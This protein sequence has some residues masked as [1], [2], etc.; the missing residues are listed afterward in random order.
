MLARASA[1]LRRSVSA[2]S[3]PVVTQT[4]A[5]GMGTS[6]APLFDKILIANRGEIVGRVA[7]T[8]NRMGEDVDSVS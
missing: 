4:A 3:W 5:R 1:A 8:A 2:S 6:E 7:R